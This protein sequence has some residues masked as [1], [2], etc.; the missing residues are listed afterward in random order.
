MT[1]SIRSRLGDLEE[2]ATGVGGCR[3]CRGTSVRLHQDGGG[4]VRRQA[5]EGAYG[6]G[7]QRDRGGRWVCPSCGRAPGVLADVAAGENRSLEISG[8][9]GRPIVVGVDLEKFLNG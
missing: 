8:T 5:T 1:N 6:P 4:G 7:W 3:L 9:S 2:L